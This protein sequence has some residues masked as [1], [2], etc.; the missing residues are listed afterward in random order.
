MICRQCMRTKRPYNISKRRA[1]KRN[2]K[3]RTELEKKR[4]QENSIEEQQ[5]TISE[6][7]EDVQLAQSVYNRRL[8][9]LM[10]LPGFVG[11]PFF[12]GRDT[13]EFLE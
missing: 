4:K 5:E 3:K 9:M 8:L 11:V 2:K 7:A 12:R 6:E 1:G 10:P 13:T